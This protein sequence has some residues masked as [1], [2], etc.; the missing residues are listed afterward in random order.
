MVG[1]L[2]LQA[3]RGHRGTCLLTRGLWFGLAAPG[4]PL[5]VTF[6]FSF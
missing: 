3:T 2:V 4:L 1:A 6:W 5:R